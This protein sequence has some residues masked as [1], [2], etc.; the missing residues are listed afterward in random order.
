MFFFWF[1]SSLILLIWSH[2][3]VCPLVQ[4][5]LC[6]VESELRE[7][8]DQAEDNDVICIDFLIFSNCW[9]NEP[10][11]CFD[12]EQQWTRFEYTKW[13]K[14]I[15]LFTRKSNFILS[16]IYIKYITILPWFER[17]VM[18]VHQ[19]LRNHNHESNWWNRYRICTESNYHVKRYCSQRRSHSTTR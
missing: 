1:K 2:F 10:S 15:S 18:S 14:F 16:L 19:M 11:F 8:A 4:Y 5:F 12:A 9:K 3:L 6:P 7:L 13:N 17:N